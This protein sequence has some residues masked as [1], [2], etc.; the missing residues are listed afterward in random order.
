[1]GYKLLKLIKIKNIQP[2]WPD[3]LDRCLDIM[4]I[5]VIDNASGRFEPNPE[6]STQGSKLNPYE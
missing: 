5:S 1:M 6:T 3:I 4:P 2:Y